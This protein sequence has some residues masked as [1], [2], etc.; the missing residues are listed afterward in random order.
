VKQFITL[1]KY[2]GHNPA[3]PIH[4]NV[5]RITAVEKTPG[6]GTPTTT[7]WGIELESGKPLEVVESAGHVL[8]LLSGRRHS[9]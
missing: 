3:T 6:M 5:D 9:G 4:V 1:S 8:E 7:V 2:N